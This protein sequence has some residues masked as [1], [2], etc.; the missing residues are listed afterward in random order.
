MGSSGASRETARPHE[1]A[2][3]LKGIAIAVTVGVFALAWGLV[4]HNV[5][6]ATNAETQPASIPGSDYFDSAESQPVPI[7][8]GLGTSSTPVGRSGAS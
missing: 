2:R 3:R 8:P 1:L 4:S 5:V 7:T 6:G